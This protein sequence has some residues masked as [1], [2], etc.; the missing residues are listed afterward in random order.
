MPSMDIPNYKIAGG[1]GLMGGDRRHLMGERKVTYAQNISPSV[2]PAY[3]TGVVIETSPTL[4]P[5][6]FADLS[7]QPTVA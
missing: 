2:L 7:P 6:S 1:W 5:N 3:S 4:E